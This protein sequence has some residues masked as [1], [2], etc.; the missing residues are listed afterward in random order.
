MKLSVSAGWGFELTQAESFTL[1]CGYGRGTSVLEMLDALDQVNGRPVKRVLGERRAGDPPQLVAS[2]RRL[3]ERLGWE[4]RYADTATIIR[5]A[6]EWERR[7][8]S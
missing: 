7:L 8:A 2:N 5:S 4:P 3:V 1:N 6:L